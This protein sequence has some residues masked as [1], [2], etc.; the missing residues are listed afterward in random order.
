MMRF[1]KHPLFLSILTVVIAY[2]VFAKVLNPPVPAS[3][4]IQYLV[5]IA[6]STVLVSTFDNGTAAEF[7]APIMAVL[8][9]PRLKALR[10][11]TL[12]VVMGGSGYLA[13]NFVKPSTSS[14]VELRTVHPA[15]PST[16]KVYGKTYDLQT[17]ANPYREF[18]ESS[19]EFRTAVKDGGDLYYKNCIFCHGD[20]LNGEGHFASA[21][22]PRPINFQDVGMIAQ[23]QESFLFWRITQ[24]G[25]GLPREGTPWNSAMPVWHEMLQEDEVWKII[26]FLYDYTGFEPRSWELDTSKPADTAAPATTDGSFDVDE[27]YAK[28]CSQC[29]GED[30]D[31]LGVVA[32]RLYPK[33]RDFT[34]GLFKYKTTDA[35]TEFPSDD[36]LRR[37][38][39]D[40]LTGTAMPAWGEI[41]SDAEVDAL[42]Q[43]IKEFGYWDEEEVEYTPIDMGT[44]P[45]ATPELLAL[46]KEQFEKTCMQCHG[47]EGRGNVTSGKILKD[48]TGD[49]IWPRNLTKPE[50]WRYT[51]TAE[52]VFQRLSVGIPGTP[53]PEHTTAVSMENRWAIAQYVMTLRDKSVPLSEGDTVIR[54]TRIEGDLP[55]DPKDPVWE[56]APALTFMMAP[57]V[58]KEPR[59]FTSL[60]HMVTA[61]A[62]YNGS[63]I[64]IRVD[65]DDRTYSVP[66]DEL[67]RR[68]ALKDVT[69]TRDAIAIQLPSELSAT[70]EKPMFRLGD[71]EHP[72]N[73]WYWAAP[74]VDPAIPET[75][76][77]MDARGSDKAP[78]AREDSAELTARGEWT[79]GRW[80]VVFKR[81]LQT[82]VPADLQFAQGQ[83]I[84][85]AFANWDGLD[86]QEGARRSF[87]DW[88]WITLE[89]DESPARLYGIPAATGLFAGFLFLLAVRWAKRRRNG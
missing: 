73:L 18:D 85:I 15:P 32:D 28:R 64:A 52:D 46:G 14:P 2:V 58:I 21:F 40:G 72:V 63:D 30:G 11:A 4:L 82:D 65:L 6:I 1:L 13:Y 79:T 43:K 59:L 66:G 25:P 38:I 3:L 39:K 10:W 29:H 54:A 50:L 55:T 88:Y 27:V 56:T 49:R 47:E 26:T 5:I 74:S 45:E 78:V 22:N 71:K 81:P 16:L 80:Q 61:R 69:P 53:M 34:L 17:L 12:L 62:L 57:N 84:P 75:A 67:E 33:P 89:A 37:T 41:L 42:I 9:S 70:G 76:V 20:M 51:R 86:G 24:G 87:T 60:N 36:D 83:Y 68:Y 23:L 8:G 77:I 35:D 31:G 44:K 48:D 7:V 19:E